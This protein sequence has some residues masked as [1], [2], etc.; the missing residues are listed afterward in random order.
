MVDGLS[1]LTAHTRIGLWKASTL[2]LRSLSKLVT[3]GFQSWSH[4]VGGCCQFQR[5]ATCL[6][7]TI[8]SESKH[9]TL[10]SALLLA[11]EQRNA[12]G[13]RYNDYERYR[14]DPT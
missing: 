13:L 8:R 14:L 7:Y 11:N 2:H 10:H 1:D 3:I 5:S 12:Y 9:L 6:S 4:Y